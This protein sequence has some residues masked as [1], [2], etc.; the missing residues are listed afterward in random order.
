M[1]HC[2][3]LVRRRVFVVEFCAGRLPQTRQF[4]LCVS[5]GGDLLQFLLASHKMKPLFIFLYP[6][7]IRACGH[8]SLSE[9]IEMITQVSCRF[10]RWFKFTLKP[11]NSMVAGISFQ[12]FGTLPIGIFLSNLDSRHLMTSPRTLLGQF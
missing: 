1:Y 8:K 4:H 7:E 2:R 12:Q 9:V 5:A 10:F 11:P 6:Y 3:H